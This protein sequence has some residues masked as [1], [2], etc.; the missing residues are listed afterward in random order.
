M[1][2]AIRVERVEE[3]GDCTEREEGRTN[4]DQM[5]TG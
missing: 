2:N 5:T 1:G 3:E 4:L